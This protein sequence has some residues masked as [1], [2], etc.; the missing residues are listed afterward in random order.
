M[1]KIIL[2]SLM[3]S[4]ALYAQMLGVSPS[5]RM[6]KKVREFV[7]LQR[8][9]NDVRKVVLNKDVLGRKKNGPLATTNA[10]TFVVENE[11]RMPVMIFDAGEIH[12]DVE[13]ISG[14]YD[15]GENGGNPTFML[16]G[17]KVSQKEFETGHSQWEKRYHSSMRDR[18]DVSV[19]NLTAKEIESLVNSG[20]NDVVVQEVSVGKDES[21]IQIGYS[22]DKYAPIGE[23]F[24]ELYITSSGYDKG[25]KGKGVGVYYSERTGC[26]DNGFASKDSD[27]EILSCNST[28][29]HGTKIHRTI[30]TVAPKAHIY[31]LSHEDDNASYPVVIHP[32]NPRDSKYPVP[33]Y[34]GNHSYGETGAEYGYDYGNT[35]TNFDME[36]DNY[37]YKYRSTEFSSA[38]NGGLN[39]PVTS[40]AKA[41]NV[42]TVG[43]V[44]PRN[45]YIFDKHTSFGNPVPGNAKP[46]IANVA[47]FVFNADVPYSGLSQ[48]SFGSTSGASAFSAGMAALLMEKLPV[49]KWHPEMV[50]AVFLA[51]KKKTPSNMSLNYDDSHKPGVAAFNYMVNSKVGFVDAAN[52]ELFKNGSDYVF[53]VKGLTAGAKYR[54]AISWLNSGS[55]IWHEK[56]IGQDFDLEVLQ[57]GVSK[58]LG[59]SK[60]RVNPFEIVEFTAGN[61]KNLKLHVKR[62]ANNNT[63]DRVIL[64]YCVTRI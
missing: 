38:G 30:R 21:T 34:I 42:I 6:S 4:S 22:S 31:G 58:S 54:V 47:N 16:N 55:Y 1:N 59:S 37:V 36:M 8:S 14:S 24:N 10:T 9:R 61:G 3:A 26:S 2:M 39:S 23:L 20:F 28:G 35:Y 40:P 60:S 45:E 57:D 41:F 17:K 46:E 56:K 63:A 27:Y 32:R 44:L 64:G 53:T 43:A 29:N 13:S 19:R 62:Y 33:I 25:I 48:G 11:E 50:K 5:E 51:S 49:L 7:E 15:P 18:A 12:S 52:D